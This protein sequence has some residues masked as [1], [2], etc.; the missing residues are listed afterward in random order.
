[1]SI[2][3]ATLGF[4]CYALVWQA[5]ASA[6]IVLLWNWSATKVRLSNIHF[7]APLRRIWRFSIYQAGF[8]TV[9]Y[10]ARNLDNLLVGAIMGSKQLGFYDKAYRLMGYPINYL[11]GIFSDVLQPYLSVYQDQ[12]RKLYE[13]WVGICRILALVGMF[14]TAVFAVFPDE[15][16]LIMFG[17][18]WKPAAPV[19]VTLGLSVGVQ[20]VNSTSGAI[21]QSAGRTDELL[22]SGLICT[23]VSIVAILCGVATGSLALL[24]LCISISYCIHFGITVRLLVMKVLGV[25]AGEFLKTFV[26]STAAAV[27]GVTLG[28]IA[29]AVV[30]QFGTA[31]A[32]VAKAAGCVAGYALVILVT[33]EWHALGVFRDMKRLGTEI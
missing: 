26:P 25:K 22:K 14:V 3:L 11:T 1:M 31:L 6:G 23:G 32:I 33:K 19:L 4:G 2:G 29:G 15:I 10:F 30:L 5:V 13:S 7:I 24:G 28:L 20:M 9:N 17:D 16:I 18:Q 27:A 8:S 21:F 12:R